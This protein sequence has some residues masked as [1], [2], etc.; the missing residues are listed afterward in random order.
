MY[1]D[2]FGF[3]VFP[4]ENNFN[5]QFFFQSK[6]HKEA[7]SRMEYIVENRK[8]CGVISGPYG[9]GKT[10]ILKMLIKNLSK[11]GYIF[12]EVINPNV[13]ELGILKL[14]AYNFL[15]YKLPQTKADILIALEKF[16]KDTSRDAKH[17][18][19]L[20]DEAQ[21]INDEKVFEELRMLLN[22]TSNDKPLLSLI[23]CGQ[24]E[25]NEKI[26]SNKQ[27]MQRVYLSYEIK[28]LD[29]KETIE[30]ISYRLSVAG[31]D[32]EIFDNE[33]LDYIYSKTGGIPRR[34]NSICDVSLLTAFSK[35]SKRV[36]Y[37]IVE[38]AYLS[39]AGEE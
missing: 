32:F 16:L 38:E 24:S 22:Y 9:C 15:N 30:Y 7:Y 28:P 13:D 6:T 20:I 26:S 11:K 3:K 37:D 31:C 12:S 5:N 2:F 27:F 14:I 17:C 23:L 25:L 21:N 36:T 29:E 35:N 18:V 39:I 4:F 34:I 33:A 1:L 8:F 10:Y 19:V